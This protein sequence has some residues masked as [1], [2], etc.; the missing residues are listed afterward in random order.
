M[1]DQAQGVIPHLVVNDAAAAL[2][3]Y[4]KGLGATEAMRLPADDGKRIMHSEISVNGARVFVRDAF[5]EFCGSGGNHRD[6][7]PD[8]LGGSPVT[9]HLEVANC[10]E[11]MKRAEAA[12]AKVIMPAMDAFWGARYGV[13][14]DPFGH[15]WSFAHPLAGDTQPFVISRVFAAPRE[16]VWKMWTEAEHLKNWF[17]P[18]G[19]KI[20][21]GKVDLRP[22]GMFHYGLETP[23]GQKLWGRFLYREINPPSRLVYVNSFAD[24]K[25]NPTRHPWDASWPLEWLSTI[26]FETHEGGTKVTVM[27]LPINASE[28]ERKTFTEGF[29]SMQGGWGGTLDQLT[30]YLKKV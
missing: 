14:V 5:P 16:T 29:A 26:M 1:A 17:G 15:S 30:A 25:G 18:K 8:A 6:A 24:E 22:G 9:M 27:W 19:F 4:K 13:I 10:D 12:G 23:Q 3:F 2:E 21:S 11:S 28:T 20:L 7:S